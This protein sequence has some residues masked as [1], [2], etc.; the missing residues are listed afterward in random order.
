[1][2]VNVETL[3]KLERRM[4][5]SLP[6][7]SVQGEMQKR[8]RRLARSVKMDGFRPGKV[9]MS[10]VEQRYGPSVR[11]EVM[12]DLVGEAFYKAAQEAKLR[13]AGQ[14]NISEIDGAADGEMNFE[15]KFEVLPEVKQGDLSGTE[16]EKVVVEV[17]EDAVERT[18]D[19]LPELADWGKNKKQKKTTENKVHLEHY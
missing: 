7:D 9:P 13:L 1:M 19:I 8:L 16:V 10:I 4:T 14:P 3:E 2:A 17:G 6:L 5:L 15:A 11:Y 12:N 18:L